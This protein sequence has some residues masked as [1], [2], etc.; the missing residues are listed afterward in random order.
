LIHHEFLVYFKYSTVTSINVYR[1]SVTEFP[2][3][4]I[5]SNN[6]FNTKNGN[7]YLNDLNLETNEKLN[8]ISNIKNIQ[9]RLNYAKS[10]LLKDKISFNNITF[11]KSLSSNLE[12]MMLSCYFLSNPCDL[13]DFEYFFSIN[14]GNCYRFNS[15]YDS[16][17]RKT[18]IRNIITSGVTNSLQIELFLGEQD[19][20]SQILF[21]NDV[22][23][24]VHNKSYRDILSTDGFHMPTGKAAYIGIIACN[25]NHFI[26]FPKIIL[27]KGI[28]RRMHEKLADPF[29]NCVKNTLS[30][31]AYNSELFKRTIKMAG[32]YKHFYCYKLCV[33]YNLVFF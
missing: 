15:G 32:V 24:A 25:Y 11:R 3:V 5:C 30:E 23:I 12:E 33:L 8:T 13:N 21:E 17:N 19:I 18:S 22:Y 10:A 9:N 16:L 29:S 14:Y 31:D 7:K 27:K 6:L 20:N 2:T 1:D 26:F 28:K 4:T